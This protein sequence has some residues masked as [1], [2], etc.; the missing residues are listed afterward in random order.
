MRSINLIDFKE[1][2]VHVLLETQDMPVDCYAYKKM[3]LT[4]TADGR[5]KVIFVT[6][7]QNMANTVCEE[8]VLARYFMKALHAASNGSLD[9]NEKK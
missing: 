1:R 7:D 5:L 2:K 4:T 3:C 6:S 8:I 9:E